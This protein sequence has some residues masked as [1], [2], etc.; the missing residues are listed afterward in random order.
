[1]HGREF[2]PTWTRLASTA[3]PGDRA[4]ALQEPVNWQPG[5]LVA[6]ATSIWR[7]EF[8]NQNEVTNAF[9]DCLF[10]GAQVLTIVDIFMQVMVIKSVAPN[11][12]SVELSASLKFHHYGVRIS[13]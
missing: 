10:S 3:A 7:D 8:E 1:M 6:V 11:Q 12:L 5:Q 9:A 2:T 13:E 4:L